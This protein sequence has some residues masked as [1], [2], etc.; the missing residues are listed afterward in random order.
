MTDQSNA[1]DDLEPGALKVG[2]GGILVLLPV[3]AKRDHACAAS[4]HLE[5]AVIKE[6]AERVGGGT[7]HEWGAGGE[8]LHGAGHSGKVGALNLMPWGGGVVHGDEQPPVRWEETG[9]IY[10]PHHK[11][12][13]VSGSIP[14]SSRPSPPLHMKAAAE[15]LSVVR[16]Q[17]V[18]ARE[19]RALNLNPKR[20]SE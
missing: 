13:E 3:L 2:Q 18:A 17:F 6:A 20:P 19:A 14:P 8:A 5:P 11:V 7:S 1:R 15:Q 9:G 16:Q 10:A 12:E 4:C